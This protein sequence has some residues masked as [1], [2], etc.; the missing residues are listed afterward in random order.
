MI[1]FN[2]DFWESFG[3]SFSE[4]MSRNDTVRAA[5]ASRP[6]NILIA[7]LTDRLRAA[8]EQETKLAL[9]RKQLY[10]QGKPLHIFLTCTDTQKCEKT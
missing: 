6:W 4:V 1:G 3:E 9:A 7:V 5:F 10:I 2:A 8:Y